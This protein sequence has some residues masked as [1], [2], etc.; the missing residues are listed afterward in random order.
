MESSE[1]PAR[2]LQITTTNQTTAAV[3][4]EPLRVLQ[5]FRSGKLLKWFPGS[6]LRHD[7]YFGWHMVCSTVHKKPCGAAVQREQ[8]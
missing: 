2:L 7:V 6:A 3:G 4:Q 5:T 1:C 8:F